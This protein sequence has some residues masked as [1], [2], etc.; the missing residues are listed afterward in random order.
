MNSAA[1]GMRYSG[2]SILE[3]RN[4]LTLWQKL[5]I[6]AGFAVLFG[7]AAQARIPLP[8]T[9]IPVTG[10]T[11]VALLA[12]LV[13][14]GE[15]GALSAILFG[16]AGLAGVPWLNGMSSGIGATSGY[17][18]GFVLA[19]AFTGHFGTACL[20]GGFG[21]TLTIA[22]FAAIVLVYIPG[23]IWLGF[24]LRNAGIDFSVASL[25]SMGA[26]PFVP[27]DLLKCILLAGMVSGSHRAIERQAGYPLV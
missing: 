20:T 14:G 4:S 2:L 17:L 23:L 3:W 1:I 10:E 18:L 9:P 11:F 16:A 27:G 19:A 5:A 12:G 24:W 21:K 15:W 13:L 6:T 22:S 8:W 25:L 7:I 26:L